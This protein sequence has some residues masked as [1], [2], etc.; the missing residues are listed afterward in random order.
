MFKW[1]TSQSFLLKANSWMRTLNF[2]AP[3]WRPG[4]R[5]TTT[6]QPWPRRRVY[7]TARFASR[8]PT[9]WKGYGIWAKQ[10]SPC[11]L[12]KTMWARYPAW[13]ETLSFWGRKGSRIQSQINAFSEP[14]VLNCAGCW[15]IES[16]Y[17]TCTSSFVLLPNQNNVAMVDLCLR[18]FP[19][20]G[21]GDLGCPVILVIVLGFV[22]KCRS[23]SGQLWNSKDKTAVLSSKMQR[24]ENVPV[25]S[26]LVLYKMHI[27]GDAPV[28]SLL[29]VKK[30]TGII[31]ENFSTATKVY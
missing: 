21:L 17:C 8:V 23:H 12:W 3:R 24:T 13:V 31:V 4:S 29:F 20:H 11:F 5:A 19:Y 18:L 22:C 25:H 30:R 6:F 15:N 9:C 14:R 1:H 10:A 26:T 28:H 2:Y 27:S 7:F 16:N